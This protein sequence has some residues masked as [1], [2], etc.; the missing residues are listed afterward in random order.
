MEAGEGASP[1]CA[2]GVY[3]SAADVERVK[4]ERERGW[5]TVP[6]H[7]CHQPPHAPPPFFAKPSTAA[8]VH[9]CARPAQKKLGGQTSAYL[10]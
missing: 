3:M 9:E 7:S 4:R 2:T 8:S 1:L 10:A 6:P 5:E